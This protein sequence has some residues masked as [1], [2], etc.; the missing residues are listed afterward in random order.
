MGDWRD[1][2]IGAA[3]RGENPTVLARL[4]G[5]FAVIGDVAA[6]RRDFLD[7]VEVL[8]AAVEGAYAELDPPFRRDVLRAA[9]TRRLS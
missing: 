9:L 8:A 7:S 1:D 5:G 3:L 4:P 6:A 2:R